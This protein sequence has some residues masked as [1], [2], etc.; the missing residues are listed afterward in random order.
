MLKQ[1]GDDLEKGTFAKFLPVA[2][3]WNSCLSPSSRLIQSR[4]QVDIFLLEENGTFYR[5]TSNEIV[6]SVPSWGRSLI[7]K[8]DAVD[9]EVTNSPVKFS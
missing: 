6:D 1:K 2:S 8:N 5:I 3:Y 4:G 7:N 9:I